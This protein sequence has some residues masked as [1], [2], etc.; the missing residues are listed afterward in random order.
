M[1]FL[2]SFGLLVCV[3]LTVLPLLGDD[4]TSAR[5]LKGGIHNHSTNSDGD[6]SPKTVVEWFIRNDYD[7]AAITDHN[8]FSDP[9]ELNRKY[10]NKDFLLLGGEEISLRVGSVPLH[11]VGLN[12]KG[13]VR[14][15]YGRTLVEAMTRNFKAIRQQGGIPQISHP[16]RDWGLS[17]QDL[18]S[19]V[20]WRLLEIY[21]ASP[22]SRND[23][24]DEHP[25]VEA[26]WDMILSAGR[27]VYGIGVDDAHHFKGNRFLGARVAGKVW[28]WVRARELT[29]EAIGAALEL[30]NFYSSTGPK[31]KEWNVLPDA[32]KVSV[33][34]Q[35]SRHYT[36]QFIGKDG[37]LLHESQGVEAT[38]EFS[39]DEVYV[40]PKIMDS[41]GKTAWLQP[42]FLDGRTEPISA[43]VI[44]ATNE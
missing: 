31:V 43:E 6:S 8:F 14:P 2:L 33:E 32:V 16:N 13:F 26:M 37:I 9:A 27:E 12:I 38:Y 5:W 15:Q 24:D 41:K 10:G 4:A 19:A 39:G 35:K 34:P 23:G 11:I 28:V 30:G 3:G 29:S 40:R 7:F 1:R 36:I 22:N 21:N 18:I 44:S 25:S 20:G 42:T 17:A